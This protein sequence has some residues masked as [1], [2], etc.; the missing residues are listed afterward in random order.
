[1]YRLLVIFFL[2]LFFAVEAKAQFGPIGYDFKDPYVEFDNLRFAV[3]ISTEVNI[4]CPDLKSLEI[5]DSLPGRLAVKSKLLSAAGGQL[6]S[7]GK[8]EMEI[9]KVAAGRYS[10]TVKGSHPTE[11]CNTVLVLI[12]GI[13]VKTMISEYP[14]TNGVKKLEQTGAIRVSYPSRSA[15]MP[16]IFLS[17]PSEEWYVLSK[18]RQIRRK[19][20]ACSYDHLS[21]EPVVILSHDEDARHL[22]TSINSPAWIIGSNQSRLQ[23]AME[24]CADLEKHFGLVP[25]KKK[26]DTKWV[27]GLKL[28]AFFHGIHWT[29]HMFNTYAQIGDALEQICQTIDGENVMAF[30]PAWDGRYY[31]TYPEH[32]PDARMGGPEGLKELVDRAHE[33][34]IK[35][36]LMLGGP[37]LSTFSF[38]KGHDMMDAA[39][40]GPDGY[41][42]IQNWLDWNMDLAIETMGLIMNFG[43]PDY[44]QYM[45]DKTSELFDV[46]N[47]DGIFLDGTLRWDNCPDYSPY[48]GLVKYTS[49]LRKRYPGKLLMGEDGYDVVYGLFDMFHTSRGPLGLE[50][51]LLRY[52]RQFYYLSYPSLNGSSGVHEI[53]WSLASPTINN[54]DPAYTIPSISLFGDSFEQYGQKIQEK[55]SDVK[56][57]KLKTCPIMTE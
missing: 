53:G 13:D 20:F 51:F 25:H 16:L 15:T 11:I 48:E 41:P 7:P 56:N 30:L 24:R 5:D 19:G 50:N 36:V 8:L 27:D 12:K 14:Q 57:W 4:Y 47:V 9:I 43:H 21:K 34:N 52:T 46:Y 6:S 32:Q 23:V 3:R 55:L 18:D 37:N 10:V 29:G 54:A 35:V 2:A 1:M 22:S 44:R 38:L 17:T 42:Q 40:K 28:A 33:L 39:L 45:I 31:C 49:A 26:P